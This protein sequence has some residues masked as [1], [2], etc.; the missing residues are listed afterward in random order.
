MAEFFVDLK[1]QDQWQRKITKEATDRRDE[2]GARATA[3]HR[4]LLLPA[5]PRQRA[6][7]HFA[8]RRPDRDQ[9]LRRRPRSPARQS[10]ASSARVSGVRGVAR[11]FID[12]AGE[13]PQLQIEIDRERAARYGLNVADIQNVI[14]TAIGGKEATADLGGRKQV[15][16]GGP[17]A[18][19]A[20]RQSGPICAMLHRH[21]QRVPHSAG[22]RGAH[23]S[24]R[25]AA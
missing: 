22:G 17:A 24:A 7:K 21:A 19:R 14:E 4:A 1:P 16:R 10:R 5:H 2:Q 18:R 9:A 6:G 23:R 15:R 3:R 25:A 20:A 13:M 11:A 8:N 12:R